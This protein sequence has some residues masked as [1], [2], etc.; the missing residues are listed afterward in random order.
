LINSLKT[1]SDKSSNTLDVAAKAITDVQ[2]RLNETM[3]GVAKL[4]A[5]SDQQI[6]QRGADLH[7]L[8]TSTNETVQQARETLNGLRS[9]TSTRGTAR[10]NLE[11]TLRDLAASAASLRGFANDIEHNPQVLLTG[12]RP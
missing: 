12:R 6:S 5:T 1:L 4:T 3:A 7:E 11:S 8:L 10:V 2:G 9:L